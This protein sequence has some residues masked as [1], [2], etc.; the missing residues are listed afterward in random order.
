MELILGA[1]DTSQRLFFGRSNLPRWFMYIPVPC[2]R[3]CYHPWGLHVSGAESPLGIFPR[4]IPEK[5]V[6]RGVDKGKGWTPPDIRLAHSLG[7]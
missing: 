4:R 1:I 2:W 7:A 6:A 3:R 5:E